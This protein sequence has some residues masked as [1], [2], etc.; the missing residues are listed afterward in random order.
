FYSHMFVLHATASPCLYPLSLHDA[1]PISFPSVRFTLT[2]SDRSTL[3]LP[4][5]GE[6]P[7]GR[8]ARVAQVMG[9]DFPDNA[10]AID[11]TR[12]GVHLDRKSTRLNSSHGSISYAVF[13]LKKKR[14]V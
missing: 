11:A 12:D 2:G 1:L 4:A 14:Q 3:E 13:C 5:T 8:L 7:E 9:A 6:T 10:I